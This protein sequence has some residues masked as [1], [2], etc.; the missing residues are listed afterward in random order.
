[1][2]ELLADRAI[3]GLMPEEHEELRRLKESV[4]EFDDQCMEKAAA[5]VQLAFTP[6]EPLPAAVHAKIRASWKAESR[7][8]NDSELPAQAADQRRE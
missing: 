4:P 1:L 6:V 2:L 8:N 7:R 5:T 3:F